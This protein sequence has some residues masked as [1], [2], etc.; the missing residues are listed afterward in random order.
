MSEQERA[1]ATRLECL[2]AA[3]LT[4]VTV[5]RATHGVP[6]IINR[7]IKTLEALR[8]AG[9]PVNPTTIESTEKPR[10]PEAG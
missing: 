4:T 1:E 3:I 9:G 6:Y 2:V 5:D 10:V 8:L 7:Y